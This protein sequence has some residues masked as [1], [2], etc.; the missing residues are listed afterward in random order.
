MPKT[1]ES[2][3]FRGRQMHSKSSPI[4]HTNTIHGQRSKITYKEE[5]QQIKETT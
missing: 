4:I 5:K 1:R 3:E 2:F